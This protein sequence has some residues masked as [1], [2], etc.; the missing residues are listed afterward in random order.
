MIIAVPLVIAGPWYLARAQSP[1]SALD[2]LSHQLA[3]GHSVANLSRELVLFPIYWNYSPLVTTLG[4]AAAVTYVGYLLRL[5]VFRSCL[6]P[7]NES[8][9]VVLA[10][11]MIGAV[12]S[13]PVLALSGMG[14]NIRWHI[15]AVYL[16]ILSFGVFGRLK[17]PSLRFLGLGAAGLGAV[18]QLTAAYV[19][20]L[21]VPSLLR[22]P[23]LGY[24]PLPSA[25]PIGSEILARDIAR[26]EKLVG[27][28]KPGEFVFFLYH[29]HSGPHFGS[30]EFYLPSVGS[31]LAG[32]V[33]AFWNRPVNVENIFGAK[34][35]VEAVARYTTAIWID[36]ESRRYQQLT[37]RLPVA[38]RNLLV[39]VSDV[40]ARLG[41]FK[42]YYVPRERITREMVLST[43]ETG[44]QLETV[45]PFLVFWDAQRIIWR[46]RFETVEGNAS[47]RDEID[48]V[49]AR[50]PVSES[51]L[52]PMNRAALHEF[53][54]RIKEL[55]SRVELRAS[56]NRD[57]D[58]EGTEVG[59]RSR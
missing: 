52:T 56:S 17:A 23:D 4:I 39:E 44:R 11:A 31:N 24:A 43:I 28:T 33:G 12:G 46:A 8:Q 32:R 50:V 2:L 10:S 20:P 37:E 13:L 27:G 14:S 51:A 3:A 40:D 7:V 16:F 57:A 15:E 6:R 26:H 30:V 19:S 38:F 42:A 41:R 29:E 9:H 58:R 59:D 22:V 55:R 21:R 36:E 34:Y 25:I 54:V 53:L 48:D 49:V 47:L 5:P 35:L 45:K 18:L 1:S